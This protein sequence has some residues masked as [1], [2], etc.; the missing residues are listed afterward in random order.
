[1]G[2]MSYKKKLLH[3]LDM[4]SGSLTE[5]HRRVSILVEVF[6][7]ADFRAD[8]GTDDFELAEKLD[9][10]VDD[11]ALKFLELRSVLAAFPSAEAWS[12]ASLRSLYDEATKCAA[13]GV[14]QVDDGPTRTVHRA[15]IKEVRDLESRLK[16]AEFSTRTLT[17]E[18]SELRAEN[19]RLVTENARLEG[20]IVELERAL[21]RTR[22]PA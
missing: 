16:D 20:R 4:K 21:N 2:K 9:K 15:T 8:N 22:V 10:Y 13:D 5:L 6:E 11:C 19:R 14:T 17:D 12:G 7:D 18:V 1:M 3:V